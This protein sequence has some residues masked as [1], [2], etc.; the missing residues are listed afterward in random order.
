MG[1]GRRS[2]G[3]NLGGIAAGIDGAR[4]PPRVRQEVRGVR[5]PGR[6]D[7]RHP[8]VLGV[9]PA[10]PGWRLS[11]RIHPASGEPLPRVRPRN[12]TTSLIG[13]RPMLARI[14]FNTSSLDGAAAFPPIDVRLMHPCQQ[15]TG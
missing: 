10:Q 11:P 5:W 4:P 6:N 2:S 9:L 14:S 8:S 1:A 7:Q 3:G 15:Q 12:L 13:G